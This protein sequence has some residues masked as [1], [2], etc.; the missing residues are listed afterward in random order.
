M[1]VYFRKPLPEAIVNE[2]NELI[3]SHRF[4]VIRSSDSKE[5]SDDTAVFVDRPVLPTSKNH[6]LISS[7]T[8]VHS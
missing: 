6:P 5:P 8:R 3:V 1:M 7:R 4:K 2:C